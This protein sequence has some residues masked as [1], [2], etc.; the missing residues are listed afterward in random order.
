M[1]LVRVAMVRWVLV[2]VLFGLGRAFGQQMAITVDDLPAHDDRPPHETRLQIA[3][4]MLRT[5]VEEKLPPTYGF[6]NGLKVK[7]DPKTEQVLK[8]WRDAGQLLGNHG[9]SHA[10]LN[11]YPA[12]HFEGELRRNEPLLKKY[13]AG[14][15]WHWFRYPYLHEGNTLEKR[16]EVRAILA[17]DGYR[18]SEVNMDFGDYLW[19]GPYAR[20]VEKHDTA[21]IGRLHDTYLATA[22]A[23]I[24]TFRG[25]SQALYGRDVKYILLLHLGAFD[26]KM[27]PEL[28]ALYRER[29][30]TFISLE[31]AEKDPVY[32]QDPDMADQGGGTLLEQVASK[33]E[34]DYPEMTKP[35]RELDRICR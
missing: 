24:G 9:W 13:M 35:V 27:L 31:E 11:V 25:L 6:I 26:A 29:G 14:E 23:A 8:A 4:E 10:D 19:N 33:R 3:Q 32:L 28:L 34:M 30:F 20:C 5:L 15:D 17:R 21:A 1:G 18:I 2:L 7:G 16:R 12:S 22:D